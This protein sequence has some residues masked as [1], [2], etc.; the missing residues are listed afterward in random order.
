MNTSVPLA[1]F[2]PIGII[3]SELKSL[4]S[5]FTEVYITILTHSLVVRIHEVNV[6]YGTTG[7][8]HL[9]SLDIVL[10]ADRFAILPTVDTHKSR[11]GFIHPHVLDGLL[12][13]G[14]AARHIQQAL[15]QHRILDAFLLVE[16]TLRA[17]I[18]KHDNY[19]SPRGWDR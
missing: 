10:V 15:Q 3:L 14:S 2:I 18:D 16:A 11:D 1:G 9:G 17:P 6:P 19:R 12:D 7:I 4:S 5:V 13:T 8:L